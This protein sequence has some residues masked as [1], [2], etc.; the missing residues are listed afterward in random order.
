MASLLSFEVDWVRERRHTGGNVAKTLQEVVIS[1]TCQ[2]LFDNLC[3]AWRGDMGNHD[4]DNEKGRI[5]GNEG[6]ELKTRHIHNGCC[7]RGERK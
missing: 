3:W 2:F 5:A 1:L 7:Y 6:E 4:D